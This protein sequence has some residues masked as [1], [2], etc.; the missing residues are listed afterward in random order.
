MVKNAITDNRK[1]YDRILDDLSSLD[2]SYVLVGFQQGSITHTQTKGQRTKPAGLSMPQIA[3]QNEFG[4]DKIPARPFLRPAFDDNR[5]KIDKAID[6]E[7]DKIVGG[8]STIKKSLGLI[9]LLMEELIKRK[10][11]A[12]N[13]PPNS[14]LTIKIKKSS[15]PLIDF[16]QM[17]D[18]VASKVVVK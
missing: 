13:Y 2:N 12:V 9:G 1:E 15:K 11:R 7:Y 5:K 17:V 18:T 3:A 6:T 8:Q 16:G 14:P 4:T 10:I